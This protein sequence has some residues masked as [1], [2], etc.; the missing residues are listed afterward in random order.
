MLDRATH[1][2]ARMHEVVALLV[3]PGPGH[4]RIHDSE[5]VAVI[6]ET[7]KILG[8]LE[9]IRTGRNCFRG[10]LR[11]GAR[12][13]VEGVEMGHSPVHIEVDDPL[14]GCDLFL[15]RRIGTGP[16]EAARSGG[17]KPDSEKRAG[18]MLGEPTTSQL[19]GLIKDV[20]HGDDG[21][22][23]LTDEKK[24]LGIEESKGEVLDQFVA[25]EFG[26]GQDEVHLL[27]ARGP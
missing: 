3:S 25:A 16:E 20:F 22:V 21:V 14:G 2:V 9:S 4:E 19:V 6:R 24:F 17:E 1:L 12:L 7:G 8:N 26:I 13:H 27:G 15:G 18:G 10:P 11:L 23:E 5:M